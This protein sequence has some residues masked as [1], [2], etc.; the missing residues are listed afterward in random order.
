MRYFL[1]FFFGF[2]FCY[3]NDSTKW[4]KNTTKVHSPRKAAIYSA[5]LPGLGQAYNKSWWKIPIIYGSMGA[6]AYF[7]DFNQKKYSYVRKNLIAQ[8]DND[9]NT[10]NETGLPS[11]Q[12]SELKRQYKNR[13]DLCLAGMVAVYILQIVE[14]HVDAHLKTFDV[15]DNLT[16]NI[17]PIM[18]ERLYLT[19]GIK[20][21]FR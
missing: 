20:L 12:L 14:A 19:A 3:P 17:K 7:S 5:I 9:P 2:V 11:S 10:V 15:S 6:F 8:T 16:L 18:G 1:I 4:N 21:N 13:R